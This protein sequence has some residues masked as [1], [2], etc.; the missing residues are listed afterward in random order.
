MLKEDEILWKILAITGLKFVNRRFRKYEKYSRVLFLI[1]F[2]FS[3]T[4]LE[5]VH[6]GI[7]IKSKRFK[8]GIS[9]ILFPI[10]SAFM[11]YF[12]YS[13]RK[14]ISNALF[15]AYYYQKRYYALKKR[16]SCIIP[17]MII[18]ILS[19]PSVACI[20]TQIMV[21]FET[22]KMI[23]WTLGFEIHNVIWKR[24]VLFNANF[25]YFFT[26]VCFPFYLTFSL[27]VLLYRCSEVLHNYNTALQIQL[28]TKANKNIEIL[29]KFFHIVMFVQK[30]NE[31]LSILSFLI[32][33]KRYFHCIIGPIV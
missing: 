4:Y 13:R 23:F 25:A 15:Q 10:Y 32:Q 27:S 8:I 19:S 24:I 2:S 11:W 14:H 1:Y 30:I 28:Q 9:Y 33:F 5:I 29:E 22:E 7:I 3:L 17:L 21:D 12:A 26:C 18:I 16:S 6:F 20:L 31:V